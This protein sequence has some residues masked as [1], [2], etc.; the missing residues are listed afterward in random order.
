MPTPRRSAPASTA[1]IGTDTVAELRA[2]FPG[3]TIDEAIV[4]L[5]QAW[6]RFVAH[7]VAPGSRD[8]LK[9]R[10]SGIPDGTTR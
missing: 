8:A 1:K 10:G 5:L 6:R 3:R 4:S 7:D 9:S 2:T